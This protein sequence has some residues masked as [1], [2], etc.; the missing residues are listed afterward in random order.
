MR[1]IIALWVLLLGLPMPLLAQGIAGQWRGEYTTTLN[2]SQTVFLLQVARSKRKLI[3][4][5]TFC[6]HDCDPSRSD[7]VKIMDMKEVRNRIS[8]TVEIGEP[9]VPRLDFDGTVAGRV[10]RFTI[11]GRSPDCPN[12]S[13]K[14]G[15]GSATRSN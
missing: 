4:M 14:I 7:K 9:D 13:C 8:F 3:G 12:S 2:P 6:G 1:R 5:I 15:Q 11:K 10:F